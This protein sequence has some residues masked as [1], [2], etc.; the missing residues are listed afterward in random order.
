M[1]YKKILATITTLIP[2]VCFAQTQVTEYNPAVLAEGVVY[3]LPKTAINVETKAIKTVYVPGEFAKYADRFLHIKGVKM[4]EETNWNLEEMKI[5]TTGIP[6]TLKTFVVKQK[7][8]SS[9]SNMQLLGN[10]ILVAINTTQNIDENLVPQSTTTH[11][12]L[13]AKKYLTSEMLEASS[14]AKIA[15]LVAQEILD[16]RDSKNTI[17]RGQ[18]ESMPKDG[19]SLRIVLDDLDAQEEALMQMFVGYTDT[20][21]VYKRYA[22]CPSGNVDKECLFRFSK[23]LGFVD[24]DD[25]SGEPYYINLTDK[26]SVPLPT[27]KEAAKRKING[28]VYNIPGSAKVMISTMKN[29]IYEKEI[30][31]AQFGTVDMLNNALFNKGAAPKVLLHPATGA[32][33]RLE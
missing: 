4:Q 14:T 28:V 20:T 1:N 24:R 7:E 8:K 9:A 5:F 18:A 16:I 11:H 21:V 10:G 26:K 17:R 2:F 30:P 23:K 12:A 32:L 6:D 27:E 25:L 19:A 22:I 31:V 3:S 29:I 33:L 13:N 15:E